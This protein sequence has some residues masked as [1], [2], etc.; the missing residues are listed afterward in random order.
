[1]LMEV[2]VCIGIILDREKQPV[3][4]GSYKICGVKKTF[5][6]INSSG[7]YTKN[8]VIILVNI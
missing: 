7:K 8:L 5:A 2:E 1:M 4:Y 3:G 6:D